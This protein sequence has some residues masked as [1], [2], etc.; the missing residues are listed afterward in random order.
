MHTTDF[1]ETPLKL[2]LATELPVTNFRGR[3]L[4]FTVFHASGSESRS[5]VATAAYPPET[6]AALPGDG[7]TVS[8]S[9]KVGASVSWPTCPS[10]DSVVSN[11]CHFY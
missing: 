9:V 6:V 4:L 11:P 8:S 10:R 3:R 1:F 5:C 2:T 7:V